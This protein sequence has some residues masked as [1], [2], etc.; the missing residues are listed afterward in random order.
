MGGL[1]GGGNKNKNK[2]PKRKTEALSD[3]DKAELEVKR[4]RDRLKKYQE[5]VMYCKLINWFQ[6]KY[7]PTIS[8]KM[9]KNIYVFILLSV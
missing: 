7:T 1:F 8:N 4:Q 5:K 6:K 9:N 2:N 3:R